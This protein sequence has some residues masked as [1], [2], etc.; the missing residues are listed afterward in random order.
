[1]RSSWEDPSDFNT[2][3]ARSVARFAEAETT[4]GAWPRAFSTVATQEAQ[5]IPVTGRV[6]LRSLVSVL[7]PIVWIS[8]SVLLPRLLKLLRRASDVGVGAEDAAVVRLGF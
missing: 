1:M 7:L 4:P 2:T 5:V 6:I 8:S 3:V